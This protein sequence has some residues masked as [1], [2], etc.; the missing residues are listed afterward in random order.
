L[1]R[2]RSSR[3]ILGRREQSR[4]FIPWSSDIWL[5]Q[6]KMK[7]RTGRFGIGCLF[8]ITLLIVC[9]AVA[10]CNL[11]PG[12]A[13]H[14]AA[15]GVDVMRRFGAG[16]ELESSGRLVAATAT[17]KCNREDRMRIGIC[18]TFVSICKDESI[19]I[20]MD[21]I[22]KAAADGAQLCVL[23]EMWCCPY[24]VENFRKYADVDLP[25]KCGA[26]GETYRAACPAFAALSAIARECKVWVI[27]G[28]IPEIETSTDK[29]FNTCLTVNPDGELVGKYRKV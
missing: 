14:A 6:L 15:A 13:H 22:R 18:Q 7:L 2:Y 29:V 20:A 10:R 19:A 8:Q 23:G 12:T 5:L 26:R 27:G 16:T 4:L 1:A 17:T 11:N 25:A 28:S 9:G 21:A 3:V 24:A